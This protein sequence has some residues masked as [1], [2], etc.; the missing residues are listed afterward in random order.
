MT[1]VY[2]AILYLSV[3]LLLGWTLRIS[4]EMHKLWREHAERK[5]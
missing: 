4:A 5:Q 1:N 3:G 2:F